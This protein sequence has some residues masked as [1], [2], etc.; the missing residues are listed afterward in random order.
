VSARLRAGLFAALCVA[1]L[2]LPLSFAWRY[3]R[4][5]REGT[6]YRVRVEPI[7]PADPFRGRYVAVR[8]RIVC[9]DCADPDYGRRVFASLATDA[10]G[11]ATAAALSRDPP[12]SGDFVRGVVGGPVFRPGGEVEPGVHVVLPPDR[13]FM[14]EALAPEA[15][16]AWRERVAQQ[17]GARAAP[18]ASARVRVR[19]G[20]AAL[21]GLDV[22]GVPIERRLEGEGVRPHFTPD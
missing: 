13:Y 4:T 17:E 2:A 12:P 7:D 20:L 5:L 22:D 3:E 11:F 16:R 10:E 21:E 15:E 9:P 19:D 18:V 8:L 14:T 1:Q 6:L